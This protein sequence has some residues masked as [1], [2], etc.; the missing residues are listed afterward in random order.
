[1]KWCGHTRN[2]QGLT[3]LF[4]FI[5]MAKVEKWLQAQMELELSPPTRWQPSGVHC[6]LEPF[7]FQD[8]QSSFSPS[9]SVCG[10]RP[11][12]RFQP[13]VGL[14]SPLPTFGCQRG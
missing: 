9:F 3:L 7:S 12:S 11:R 8:T 13:R 6:P 10:A 2:M 14:V 4:T 1:M 5:N